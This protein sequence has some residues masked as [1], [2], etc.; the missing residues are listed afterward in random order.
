MNLFWFCIIC[1]CLNIAF[2]WWHIFK[3]KLI[4]AGLLLEDSKELFESMM[5]EMR[6]IDDIEK[7]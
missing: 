4:L 7:N 6:P 2:L 5:K 1:L 3:L